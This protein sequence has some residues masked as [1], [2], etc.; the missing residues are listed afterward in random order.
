[1]EETFSKFW[2]EEVRKEG[3]VERFETSKYVI[4]GSLVSVHIHCVIS[5]TTENCGEVEKLELGDVKTRS[6][7]VYDS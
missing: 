1:M 5:L 2:P 3:Q 4:Y 7:S 6:P